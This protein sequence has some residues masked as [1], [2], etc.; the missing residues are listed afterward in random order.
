M[1]H[2]N[3]LWID[4]TNQIA[5]GVMNFGDYVILLGFRG[6]SCTDYRY[7]RRIEV[8][9]EQLLE[10]GTVHT[11]F[12]TPEQEKTI[13]RIVSEDR[14]ARRKVPAAPV[15]RGGEVCA[16]C[17]EA[18]AQEGDELCSDCRAY[19]GELA[20]RV[21]GTVNHERAFKN[22]EPWYMLNIA[23][24][25]IE[26][27]YARWRLK[28]QIPQH[29]PPSDRERMMFELDLLNSGTLA[30]LEKVCGEMERKKEQ[31]KTV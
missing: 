29:Y 4:R 6:D 12:A 26:P 19:I 18:C 17:G 27:L 28:R 23:H 2:F 9:R 13:R 25:V 15:R 11:L 20:L 22:R 7:T 16:R 31:Q 10:I 14:A 21:F 30:E 5:Y 24:P 3:P 1:T 8:T